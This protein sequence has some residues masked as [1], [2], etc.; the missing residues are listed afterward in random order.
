M[1]KTNERQSAYANAIFEI[2]IMS[3]WHEKNAQTNG[4]SKSA[5]QKQA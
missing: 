1:K 5:T 2:L 4:T 3:T